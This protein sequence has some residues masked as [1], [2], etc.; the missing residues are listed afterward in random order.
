MFLRYTHH[1]VDGV[2]EQS[3]ALDW[4]DTQAEVGEHGVASGLDI[5]E[6]NHEGH[7]PL[8]LDQPLIRFVIVKFILGP[9]VTVNMELDK[10]A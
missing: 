10:A 8:T 5:R 2:P 7:Q 6:V 1:R 9:G 3:R 4:R